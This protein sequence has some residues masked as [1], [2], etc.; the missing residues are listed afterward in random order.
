MGKTFTNEIEER[1]VSIAIEQLLVA[2]VSTANTPGRI[3][4]AAPPAGFIH[5][6]A[7]VEDSP[8]LSITRE[9]YQLQTGIPRVL[10]YDAV[11]GLAGQFTMSFYSNNNRHV[12]YAL[13][14]AAPLYTYAS[15]STYDAGAGDLA[16][17]SLVSTAHGLSVDDVLQLADGGTEGSLD[18]EDPEVTVIEVTDPDTIVV[19]GQ[20]ASAG[21]DGGLGEVSRIDLPFGTSLLPKY[22][23]IGVA[24]FIDGVQVQH[25]FKKVSPV[26]EF[27]ENIQPGQANVVTANWDLFGTTTTS[28]GGSELI[29]G[30]RR[31]IPKNSAGAD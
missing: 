19:K 12:R 4:I 27:Q 2:P 15:S 24:D 9:K 25:H 3:D 18:G 20:P 22:Y 10:Q 14:G 6:G 31:Y 17:Y 16:S 1:E 26:G 8:Q 28:Y 30:E 23:L 29:L 11:L 21:T 7:V 13:G 5:L